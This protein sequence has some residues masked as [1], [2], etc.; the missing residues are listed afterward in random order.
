MIVFSF[1]FHKDSIMS[2]P[3]R[4]ATL[5]SIFVDV[6]AGLS[7]EVAAVGAATNYPYN[8]KAI[9]DPTT[10]RSADA[11]AKKMMGSEVTNDVQMLGATMDEMVENFAYYVALFIFHF[12]RDGYAL[13]NLQRDGLVDDL[14]AKTEGV[15]WHSMSLIFR[16]S[17]AVEVFD[18]RGSGGPW[19]LNM[20]P[21]RKG[22]HWLLPAQ[23]YDPRRLNDT[24]RSFLG[25]VN[26]ALA[27]LPVKSKPLHFQPMPANHCYRTLVRSQQRGQHAAHGANRND[28]RYAT[29]MYT[30]VRC[31]DLGASR[32]ATY[33]KFLQLFPKDAKLLAACLK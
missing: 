10:Y 15:G 20:Y 13:I 24:L 9:A 6:D 8:T 33:G 30:Y 23:M 27:S 26:A 31:A 5:P 14:H 16:T 22:A 19:S 2:F 18:V 29:T 25:K 7:T 17:G 1:P 32:A 11:F 4:I 3:P 21:E 12:K 28:C